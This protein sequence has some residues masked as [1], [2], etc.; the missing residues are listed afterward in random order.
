M[1]KQNCY[2]TNKVGLLRSALW[3]TRVKW[4]YKV[5]TI[6]FNSCFMYIPVS[7]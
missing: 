7:H 2:N 1:S 3:R 4:S 6:T 5:N